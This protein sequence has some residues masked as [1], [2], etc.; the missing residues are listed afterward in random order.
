MFVF[1]GRTR[2]TCPP[3]SGPGP[4]WHVPL[5]CSFRGTEH[6]ALLTAKRGDC[7]LALCLGRCRNRFHWS[8]G[9]RHP[10][11]PWLLG[12]P[13]SH[14]RTHARP[15]WGH[16]SQT[17]VW[18]HFQIKVQ[19][20][21]GKKK[22]SPEP[23]TGPHG[24]RQKLQDNASAPFPPPR[25]HLCPAETEQWEIGNRK[26]ATQTPMWK[27]EAGKHSEVAGAC[28]LVLRRFSRVRLFGTARTEAQQAPLS[29]GF[30][31]REYWSGSP[32]PP[33]GGLP[34]P[35]TISAFPALQ[36]DSTV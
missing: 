23:H 3:S 19:Q 10:L 12:T 15:L 5:A 9:G 26:T 7:S 35:G 20:T 33:P 34:N 8:T 2:A 14:N 36:A 17:P 11:L 21:W 28:M 32:R 6:G 22:S 13:S 25:P 31:R 4:A 18:L 29:M 27:R 24:S 16:G 30:P 1:R